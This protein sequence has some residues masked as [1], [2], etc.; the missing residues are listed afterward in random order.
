MKSPRHRTRYDA[1]TKQVFLQIDEVRPEDV[2]PYR[3]LAT[4]PAGE[5]STTGSVGLLPEKPGPEDQAVV[6][7]GKLRNKPGPDDKGKRPIKIVP[8]SPGQPVPTPAELRKLKPVPPVTKPEE[9]LAPEVM[10]PPKVIVPLKDTVL[11]EL[12]PVLLIATIDAGIPLA[13]VRCFVSPSESSLNMIPC[14]F[15]SSLGLKMANHSW[16]AIDIVR[17]TIFLIG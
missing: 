12:M 16:K 17:N 2:G 5:D 11:D 4:N 8:G 1:P 3:V 6:P 10:R 13:S 7:P 9:A 14:V 15:F